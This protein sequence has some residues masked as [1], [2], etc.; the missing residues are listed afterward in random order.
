MAIPFHDGG[1]AGGEKRRL[2]ITRLACAPEQD[3]LAR[4]KSD[5]QRSSVQRPVIGNVTGPLLRDL[6]LPA[7]PHAGSMCP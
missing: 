5:R 3:R 2:A 4:A 6:T 7:L 1:G